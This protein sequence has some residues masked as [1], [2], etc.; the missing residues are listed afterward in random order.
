MRDYA[1]VTQLVCLANLES[2]NAELIRMG[3]SQSERLLKLN[4]TAI[5]QMRSL[6]CNK[7]VGKLGG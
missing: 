4:E 1:N 3:M 2:I 5:V 7:S 6:L